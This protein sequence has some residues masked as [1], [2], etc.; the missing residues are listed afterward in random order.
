MPIGRT[1][2]IGCGD[3]PFI[4]R[5]DLYLSNSRAGEEQCGETS[6]DTCGKQHSVDHVDANSTSI[7]TDAC[8]ANQVPSAGYVMHP[9]GPIQRLHPVRRVRCLDK[10]P[11]LVCCLQYGSNPECSYC[12]LEGLRWVSPDL[13]LRVSGKSLISRAR[14]RPGATP[15]EAL[16]EACVRPLAVPGAWYR[17]LRLVASDGSTLALPVEQEDRAH[18]VLPGSSQDSA[19]FP[20]L[21]LAVLLEVSV[22]GCPRPGAWGRFGKRRWHRRSSL[23]HISNPR[24]GCLR[25]A[26][27]VAFRFG[28]RPLSPARNLCGGLCQT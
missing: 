28:R 17:N 16:R 20:N 5:I 4:I 18:L 10:V 6:T 12:L 14:S 26:T 2:P 13:L 21:R 19:G 15:F 24:C 23:W 3:C 1:R 7:R 9:S 11:S 8:F 25:T 22:P 27:T